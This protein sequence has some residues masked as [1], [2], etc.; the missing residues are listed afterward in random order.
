VGVWSKKRVWL[1]RGGDCAGEEAAGP[2]GPTLPHWALDAGA[3]QPLLDEALRLA[4]RIVEDA[5]RGR[6]DL[7]ELQR[8]ARRLLAGTLPSP[9][10][11]DP[12]F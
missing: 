10:D 3:P 4:E 11:P 2:S 8:R 7:G 1:T 6:V 9:G 12:L 5:E